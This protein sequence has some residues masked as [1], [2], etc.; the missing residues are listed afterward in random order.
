[1]FSRKPDGDARAQLAAI[2]RSQAVIEFEMDGSII[3][4]NGNFL[5]ALGY[6]LEEIKGKHHSM[7]LQPN[8]RDSADYRAFWAAL[9]RGEFQA[10]EFKRITKSGRELWIEASY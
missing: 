7:F 2:G 6:R 4:A 1:M 9:N 8:Q 3:T 5:D 10:G